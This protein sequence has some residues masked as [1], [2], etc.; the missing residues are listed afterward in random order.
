M[1]GLNRRGI[2]SLL[3]L[4]MLVGLCAGTWLWLGLRITVAPQRAHERAAATWQ[5]AQIDN[6]R[7]IVRVQETFRT[8]GVYDLTIENGDIIGGQI[9]SIG[10]YRYDPNPPAFE[11]DAAQSAPYTVE[12]LLIRARRLAEDLPTFNLYTPSTSHISYH[13]QIGYP[14]QVVENTCGLL[15]ND[16]IAACITDITVLEFESLRGQ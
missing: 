6:Y 1:I 14:Q 9:Y 2:L 5:A 3:S 11:I 8:S 15:A 16:A 12:N 13:P 10:A 7:I 4:A